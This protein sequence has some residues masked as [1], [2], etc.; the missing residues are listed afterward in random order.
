MK[1]I[2]ENCLTIIYKSK[3]TPTVCPH[4]ESGK[5]FDIG[6]SI[7]DHILNLESTVDRPQQASRWIPVSERLPEDNRVVIACNRSRCPAGVNFVF[8]SWFKD[9][10][11][12]YQAEMIYEC[13]V[14]VTH[15]QPLPTPPEGE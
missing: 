12:H 4:C 3:V 8:P 2:C 13:E 10:K 14:P 5:M 9:G 15:W 6:D 1:H 11:F 7:A